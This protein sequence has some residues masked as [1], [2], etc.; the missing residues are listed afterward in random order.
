MTGNQVKFTHNKATIRM[1][2]PTLGQHNYEVLKERLNYSD[3]K[4]EQLIR[5]G[6]L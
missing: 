4:I 5:S 3:E 2:A 1:P 6:I